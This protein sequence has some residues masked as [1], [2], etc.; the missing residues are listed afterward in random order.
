MS[1]FPR[2]TRVSGRG[3]PSPSSARLE[4][5]ALGHAA[6]R[7]AVDG[8]TAPVDPV[9]PERADLAEAQRGRAA[10]AAEGLVRHRDRLRVRRGLD[11][12]AVLVH[13]GRGLQGLDVVRGHYRTSCDK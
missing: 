11:H 4:L 1:W 2:T 12:G 13:G 3:P 9:I 8:K 7:V 6:V 10:R 5:L